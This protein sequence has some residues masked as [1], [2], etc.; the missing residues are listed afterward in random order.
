[1]KIEEKL[2]VALP[3][4]KEELPQDVEVELSKLVADAGRQ[5]TQQHQQQAAQRQA[6]QK[7]KDPVIQMQQKELQIKEQEVQ[8]KIAKDRADIQI[9]QQQAQTA[10]AR[11][12]SK[13]MID[14]E[15][16][17]LERAE[18]AIEAEEKGANI[19]RAMK[20]A[21]DRQNMELLRMA[22]EKKKDN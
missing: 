3:N 11:D 22:R 9:R 18:L 19:D 14:A 7:A 20:D 5:L 1:M 12:A 4:P 10:T 6:Q 17:K 15:R 2:G 8:R 16:V 13:A 21:E